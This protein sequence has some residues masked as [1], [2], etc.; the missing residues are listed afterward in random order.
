MFN[1]ICSP[2]ILW[3]IFQLFI[4]SNFQKSVSVHESRMAVILD[5]LS[6]SVRLLKGVDGCL[7]KSENG[8]GVNLKLGL[9]LVYSTDI[10]NHPIP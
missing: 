3:L 6:K 4:F 10:N 9:A 7:G 8:K 2:Q 5:N 1:E